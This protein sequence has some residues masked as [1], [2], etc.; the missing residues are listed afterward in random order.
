[1][2][3]KDALTAPEV[4]EILKVAQNTVYELVKR[5]K[6]NCYKVGRKMRFTY[7]DVQEYINTS[8]TGAKKVKEQQL[9]E[10]VSAIQSGIKWRQDTSA[11]TKNELAEH[12]SFR[13][14]G[15]DEILD[16]LAKYMNVQTPDI[17]VERV[18][19]GSYDSLVDLYKDKVMVAASHMWDAATNSYNY[20]YLIKMLPG[21]SV[22]VIRVAE[23]SQ[24]FYVAEGNPKKITSWEDLKRSDL[25]I[26]NR[27]PGAG[28][29][30]LL[31][32]HLQIMG[33][34]GNQI[35]GYHRK[36][37]SHMSV[38]GSISRGDADFGIGTEKTALNMRGVEFIPLQMEHYDLVVKKE[39]FQ[40]ERVQLMLRILQSDEFKEQFF[41]MN[42][43]DVRDMGKIVAP[44]AF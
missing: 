33:I 44:E 22:T 27:E 26:A 20:P 41:Y 3:N 38:A 1:M 12:M 8:R 17:R 2:D 18:H 30:I 16:V 6:L 43:Y 34:S 28:T 15:Q 24:G 31:D 35:P 13:L 42:G 39:N 36:Y 37:L 5:G 40:D 9:S 23:R 7:D 21:C 11:K 19:K 14:C 4:A 25:V 10:T 29:R 32:E